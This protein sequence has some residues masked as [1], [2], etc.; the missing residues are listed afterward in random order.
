MLTAPR[1]LSL[2]LLVSALSSAPLGSM[3]V[4]ERGSASVSV[5]AAGA[6]VAVAGV[7]GLVGDARARDARHHGTP[8][9]TSWAELEHLPHGPIVTH[10]DTAPSDGGLERVALIG[11]RA[12]APPSSD[13][14]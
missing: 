6:R 14:I 8:A 4:S 11:F 5:P 12:T 3:E 7:M 1:L 2:L 10:L 13:L 9:A